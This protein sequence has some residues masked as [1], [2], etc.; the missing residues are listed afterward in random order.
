METG[1]FADLVPADMFKLVFALGV[2][3]ARRAMQSL[4]LLLF[5][6]FRCTEWTLDSRSFSS[7]PLF[8]FILDVFLVREALDSAAFPALVFKLVDEE[9]LNHLPLLH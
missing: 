9:A 6:L 8:M 4:N 7:M 5:S 2:D 1:K 3:L